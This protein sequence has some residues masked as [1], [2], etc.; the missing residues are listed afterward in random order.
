ML[1]TALGQKADPN[2]RWW[3]VAG[4]CVVAEKM[5]AE[6]A[7]RVCGP[8]VA[9]MGKAVAAMV[10]DMGNPVAANGRF[11]SMVLINGFAVVAS[12]QTPAVASRSARVLADAF[13][14]E[15]GM[16]HGLALANGLATLAGRL[17]PVE[18]ERICGEAARVLADRL[19]QRQYWDDTDAATGLAVLAGRMERIEAERICGEAGPTPLQCLERRWGIRGRIMSPPPVPGE[20]LAAVAA[21]MEP[22]EAVRMLA[23]GLGREM[24]GGARM[25]LS[26]G[27]SATT[28]RLE[29]GEA[30][31]VC[32]STIRTLLRARSARP[33][34]VQDRRGFD[35]SVADLLPRLEA[36]N[37]NAQAAT[38]AAMMCSEGDICGD[39]KGDPGHPASERGPNAVGIFPCADR[40]Q[41]RRKETFVACAWPCRPSGWDW[42]R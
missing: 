33:L 28:A 25:A 40:R 20:N 42:A 39:P 13:K 17:E 41:P 2:T 19:A 26:E 37:A 31:L 10:V 27:L 23:E 8:V 32:D 1:V 4:L 22:V 36:R 9:D 21:G 3:L 24:D 7:A 38:L 15:N 34:D 30:A 16:S 29:P 18:A 11:Y 14:G 5:D 35:S 6:E 12:R